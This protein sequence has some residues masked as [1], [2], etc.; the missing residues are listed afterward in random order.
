MNCLLSRSQ[1]FTQLKADGEVRWAVLNIAA[2]LRQHESLHMRLA[3]AMEE[4]KTVGDL[5]AMIDAEV[6]PAS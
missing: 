1:Q 6:K 5:A 4:G 2:V 3:Q